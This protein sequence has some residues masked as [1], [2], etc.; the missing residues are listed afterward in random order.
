MCLDILKILRCLHRS[1]QPPLPM[2]CWTHWLST[3]ARC[4][5]VDR[6][7]SLASEVNSLGER[8]RGPMYDRSHNDNGC[9][10]G[11][12]SK[13]ALKH[14]ASTSYTYSENNVTGVWDSLADE[15]WWWR[16]RSHLQLCYSVPNDSHWPAN[17]TEALAKHLP[18]YYKKI[19][20]EYRKNF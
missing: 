14:I 9:P 6:P 2:L 20:F 8:Y 1:S 18:L 13:V 17:F 11:K 3:I 4:P 12:Q 19:S 7:V 16:N 10:A 15:G 5:T